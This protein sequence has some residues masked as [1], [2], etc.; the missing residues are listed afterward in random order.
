MARIEYGLYLNGENHC[1]VISN[2]GARYAEDIEDGTFTNPPIK[3]SVK[4][5]SRGWEYTF[6]ASDNPYNHPEIQDN[7]AAVLQGEF[8][9]WRLT[10][11]NVDKNGIYLV[12]YTAGPEVVLDNGDESCGG[13][14]CVHGSCTLLF[15]VE[16]TDGSPTERYRVKETK[17]PEIKYPDHTTREIRITEYVG[18]R[19]R[20]ELVMRGDNH[21]RPYHVGK[22]YCVIT[23]Y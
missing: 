5:L 4:S 13:Q 14:V 16:H 8:P 7:L 18:S 17:V 9:G 20:R 23:E 3:M 15:E 11:V 1:Y 10:G 2:T 19:E 12:Y 22:Q 21:G 6:D